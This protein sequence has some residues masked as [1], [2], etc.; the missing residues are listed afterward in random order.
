MTST[1]ENLIV[2]F[3]PFPGQTSG[4][5]DFTLLCLNI[6]F[7][8]LDLVRHLDAFLLS[9]FDV[10]RP[11]FCALVGKNVDES[12]EDDRQDDECTNVR[13]FGSSVLPES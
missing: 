6:S 5:L 4:C 1:R 13:S 7:E 2:D 3:P 8:R 12:V 9:E 10:A 11:N